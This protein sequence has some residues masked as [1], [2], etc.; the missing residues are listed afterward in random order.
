MRALALVLVLPALAVAGERG[1]PADSV[2]V[3]P[4]CID[5][6]EES[7]WRVADQKLVKKLQ[8][9]RV[10]LDELQKGGAEQVSPIP[11]TS[12][13]DVTYGDTFPPNGNWTAPLYAVSVA[14]VLPSTCITWFQAEQACRLSGKRLVSNEEWQAAAQG[15]PDPGEADDQA[16][17]C[18]TKSPPPGVLTG[19]R[20]KCVSTW[21]LNDMVGNAWEWTR[22]W[23]PLATACGSWPPGF[24]PDDDFSCFGFGTATPPSPAAAVHR[25]RGRI[26]DRRVRFRRV[27][28]TS[29]MPGVPSGV[30]RGG[31]FGIG[32]RGGV[33]AFHAGIPVYTRSR[34]TGF[35]CA[36]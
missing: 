36:R 28:E 18:A 6:Y 17:T 24:A 19:A 23:A 25:I 33:F 16:T 35:R 32:G 15:T 13:E 30:I 3:G 7:V 26:P 14:G 10:T 11:V 20:A 22:E 29:V 4:A 34:S 1:C 27:E 2:Q 21:G 12:C 31:N 8:R 9:G 5:R